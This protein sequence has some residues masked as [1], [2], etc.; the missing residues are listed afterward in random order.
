[1]TPIST[2]VPRKVLVVRLGA[3]GD[4]VNALVFAT[5]LKDAAPETSIGWAVHQLA[6]PLVEGHPALDHVHVW[7]RARGLDGFCHVLKEIRLQ[8]YDLAVDLQRITKSS[9][10]ARLSGAQRV[11]G[12]DRKRAKELS[13]I[14]T[15]ER[16]PEG[17]SVAHMIDQYLEFARYLGIQDPKP[18]HDLSSAPRAEK[19]AQDLV[20]KMGAAPIL[21]DLGAT[22]PANRWSPERV[23]ELAVACRSE[24]DSPVCFT[25]GLEDRGTARAALEAAYGRSAKLGLY[26]LIGCTDLKQLI[27]IC[28]RARL[29]IGCDTGPM[30]IASACG[31]PVVAL[32]GP[33]DPRRTGPFGKVGRVVRVPPPCSPCNQ[34]H[35]RQPRHACMEDITVGM[36]LRAAEASVGK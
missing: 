12:F 8:A 13:W 1:M 6:E 16:I 22:K 31:T 4:V 24:L 17:D 33:S 26:D 35:C 2:N 30:H 27:A 18:R 29:W 7:P 25:G 21:I 36:V 20:G 23:A 11:L 14:W 10:L 9:L 5:A 3:I 19:W 32:F 34:R 15:R 28:A